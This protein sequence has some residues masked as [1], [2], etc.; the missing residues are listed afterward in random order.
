[1]SVTIEGIIVE[2]L[3]SFAD[4]PDKPQVKSPVIVE[5]VKL[6]LIIFNQRALK[7]SPKSP[8]L[9]REHKKIKKFLS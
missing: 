8:L 7:D 5:A 3:K 6:I 4:D 1:M 2:K 9:L